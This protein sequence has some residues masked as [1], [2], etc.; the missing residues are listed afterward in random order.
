MKPIYL[1]K[2]LTSFYSA[3]GIRKDVLKIQEFKNLDEDIFI[4]IANGIKAEREE[5]SKFHIAGSF[6]LIT[7]RRKFILNALPMFIYLIAYLVNLI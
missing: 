7:K 4:E 3:N 6:K 5:I 1:K 2:K